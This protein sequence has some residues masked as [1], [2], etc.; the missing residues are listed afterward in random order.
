MLGF[1]W[2]WVQKV[3][4]RASHSQCMLRNA[5]SDYAALFQYFS[6]TNSLS[7]HHFIALFGV[8][9]LH[10]WIRKEEILLG[11][12]QQSIPNKLSYNLKAKSLTSA[13]W[14]YTLKLRVCL[15]FE[16]VLCTPNSLHF[17]KQKS[18]FEKSTKTGISNSALFHLY[19]YLIFAFSYSDIQQ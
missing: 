8:S 11:I 3:H 10:D 12:R 4:S 18:A 17:D 13:V 14:F 16:L 9:L 6:F 7:K 1:F 5:T 2:C 19:Q 15:F